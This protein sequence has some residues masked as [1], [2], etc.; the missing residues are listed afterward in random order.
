MSNSERGGFHVTDRIAAF[1]KGSLDPVSAK[2]VMSTLADINREDGV[3]V[4]VTLHQVAYARAFCPRAVALREGEIVYDGP[5]AALTDAALR[6]IYGEASE[7]L[8]LPEAPPAVAPRHRPAVVA[9]AFEAAT[10]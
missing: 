6:D 2:R 3:T 10:A 8:L 9:S 7:E 1:L 4:V 5:C